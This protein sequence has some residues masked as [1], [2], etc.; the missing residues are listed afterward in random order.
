M[1]NKKTKPGIGDNEDLEPNV[2]KDLDDY[3]NIKQDETLNVF[4]NGNQVTEKEY[5]PEIESKFKIWL[6][7]QAEDHAGNVPYEIDIT[8]HPTPKLDY[9][10]IKR[11][12]SIDNLLESAWDNTWH[13]KD[14]YP[15]LGV[16]Y[17]NSPEVLPN[18]LEWSSEGEDVPV[19]EPVKFNFKTHVVAQKNVVTKAAVVFTFDISGS[20]GNGNRMETTENSIAKFVSD[21]EDDPT[22]DMVYN[23]TYYTGENEGLK[24][25]GFQPT[26]TSF[27][28]NRNP[29][30]GT[31]FEKAMDGVIDAYNN[32]GMDIENYRKVVIHTSDGAS[33]ISDSNRSY[34][35]NQM[36]SLGIDQL[37]ALTTFGNSEL[38]EGMAGV[39]MLRH[40]EEEVR[41][42]DPHTGYA[43]AKVTTENIVGV[44][45]EILY[46]INGVKVYQPNGVEETLTA[47]VAGDTDIVKIMDVNELD[48]HLSQDTD[49]IIQSIVTKIEYVYGDNTIDDIH[50]NPGENISYSGY[51]NGGY[52]SAESDESNISYVH[53]DDIYVEVIDNSKYNDVYYFQDNARIEFANG[54]TIADTPT[55]LLG[56][57]D[58]E[59]NKE[60]F[61]YRNIFHY[62]NV[63][64]KDNRKEIPL[65][66]INEI[67]GLS[68]SIMQEV[69]V[70]KNDTDDPSLTQP[71]YFESHILDGDID[72]K[73]KHSD[74]DENTITSFHKFNYNDDIINDRLI[75]S[76]E[77]EGVKSVID[78][79]S[80]DKIF[81]T[82]LFYSSVN[83]RYYF[84]DK[85]NF[86][87]D[88]KHM[89]I[90]NSD[91][92]RAYILKPI[93]VG[94]TQMFDE[95][96]FKL[97]VNYI[98][99]SLTFNIDLVDSYVKDSKLNISEEV[100]IGFDGIT[101]KETKDDSTIVIESDYTEKEREETFWQS[102]G[103]EF[104]IEDIVGDDVYKTPS[105]PEFIFNNSNI[106]DYWSIPNNV[107]GPFSIS[108]QSSNELVKNK[109]NFY[110]E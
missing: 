59:Y 109:L 97:P 27:T 85:N 81:N 37:W 89:D 55:D 87:T 101:N 17:F 90:I 46:N 52:I 72:I 2:F 31:N 80:D 38:T 26:S 93:R 102:S 105:N 4:L 15:N 48:T 19:G 56:Y 68:E 71:I 34:Y 108:Y 66:N 63:V 86:V 24:Y 30:G 67:D 44:M 88:F 84:N 79:K 23:V 65:P 3:E 95:T 50:I 75:V 12:D 36:S 9:T 92:S 98:E 103:V 47:T 53:C 96:T 83:G 104:N 6:T 74:Q 39:S 35:E 76:T 73:F 29:G 77:N 1:V 16:A 60:R 110:N 41:P 43:R 33:S 40:S 94:D 99:S 51:E 10:L 42:D 64:Q 20:M 7:G 82:S 62:E 69:M 49:Y 13:S 45:D 14:Y 11:C 18:G 54:T 25:S 5:Y 32:P 8:A 58:I 28:N 70:E 22:L 21:A 57:N 78:F 100:D 106:E 91:D 61:N 107:Y